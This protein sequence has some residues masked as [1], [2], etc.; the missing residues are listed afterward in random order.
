MLVYNTR[1]EKKNCPK[2]KEKTLYL[3]PLLVKDYDWKVFV[4]LLFLGDGPSD[5]LLGHSGVP[6]R[7]RSPCLT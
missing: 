2:E 5:A 7:V 1:R 4:R 6:R 3:L